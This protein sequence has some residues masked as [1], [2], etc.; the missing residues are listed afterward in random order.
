[1]GTIKNASG[2]AHFSSWDNHILTFEVIKCHDDIKCL[3]MKHKTHFTEQL[4]KKTKSGNK[5]C[6]VYVILQK[7]SFFRKVLWKMCRLVV[8]I[9][10]KESEEVSVLIWTSFDSFANTYLTWVVYFHFPVEFVLDSLQTHRGLEHSFP[11]IFHNCLSVMA[12][13]SQI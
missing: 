7:R 13:S 4:E 2:R 5:I 6:R 12:E 9:R 10:K 3:R 8:I 1:M 11:G